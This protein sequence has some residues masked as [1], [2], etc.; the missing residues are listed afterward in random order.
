MKKSKMK[1]LLF[2]GCMLTLYLS[3]PV[4]ASDQDI[5]AQEE[6]YPDAEEETEETIEDIP[7]IVFEKC[8][9]AYKADKLEHNRANITVELKNTSS[10]VM[11]DWYLVYNSA[12]TIE[13]IHNAK[14][15][16]QGGV[17]Y[18]SNV[19]SNYAVQPGETIKFKM[20]ISFNGDYV[21][22]DEFRVYCQQ[23][24]DNK[25]RA[26][27]ESECYDTMS[28]DGETGKL[29]LHTMDASDLPDYGIEHSSSSSSGKNS[30]TNITQNEENNDLILPRNI[31]GADNR[32]KVS[33]VTTD[34]Y[35]KIALLVATRSD[36]SKSYSTGF[37]ISDKY[38][39]TAAHSVYNINK[40]IGPIG[41]VRS[42][43]AYFGRNGKSY[44]Y[45]CT[46]TKY[47]WANTYPSGKKLSNDWAVIEFNTKIGSHVGW[48][49]VGYT[50]NDKLRNMNFR[51]TGFPGDKMFKD[52]TAK[53]GYRF[54]MYQDSSKLSTIG[55]TYL[56]Y[57]AD[58]EGGQSGS[59]IYNKSSNIIYGVHHGGG[60]IDNVGRRIT[61][62]LFN[63]FKANGWIK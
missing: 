11:E 6:V 23:P 37:M 19:K 36:G 46:T 50:T 63:Q 56:K 16:V 18:L 33:N 42:I 9:V 21:Q 53:E 55:S 24:Q 52:S 43:K 17:H 3:F 47:S 7:L 32:T 28:Y 5:T 61:K 10:T 45:L 38:M 1:S 62:S 22:P 4:Q 2:L 39:L 51:V 12:S 58:T 27:Q 14:I 54:Y 34:P 26:T 29:E 60:T 57:T 48:F 35:F 41:P 59:P 49:G 40:A 8:K 13:K 25:T 44:S 15:V 30:R 20:N 31:I